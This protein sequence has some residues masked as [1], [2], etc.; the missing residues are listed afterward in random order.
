M[1]PAAGP[2]D[3]LRALRRNLLANLAGKSWGGLLNLACV[4]VYIHLMGIEAFGLVGFYLTFQAVFNV[5]DL[6]MSTTM[7]REMAK[8][9]SRSEAAQETRDL[10]RTMELVYWA[11][12]LVIGVS[13]WLL[14]PV[15]V[16]HW[17][18]VRNLDR[19][20]V[21]QCV[22]MMGVLMVLEWPL[23]LY[24][25][26]LQGTERQGLLNGVMASAAT[27]R[28]GGAILVLWLVSP[29]VTAFFVW[30]MITG[31]L[32]TAAVG[33]AFWHTLPRADR[34]A[35]FRSVLISEVAGFAGGVSAI[36][37]ESL[38]LTQSDKIVLSKILT[39]KAF[40]YYTLAW[41][42]AGGLSVVVAPVFSAFFPR[43][44]ALVH[45]GKQSE[46]VEVYHHGCELMSVVLLSAAAVFAFF[47][48]DIVAGWT[49]S[50]AIAD[51][52]YL[53]AILLVVGAALNGIAYLPYGLQ[54]AHGWTTLS[55]YMNGIV[56]L[57]MVP[58]LI[59]MAMW[60]GAIGAAIVWVLVNLSYTI[61]EV[62][63]MHRWLLHDEMSRWYISDLGLP[64]AAA[65]VIALAA[66]VIMPAP[67]AGLAGMLQIFAVLLV[68]LGFSAAIAPA[69]R[70]W[71]KAS[72]RSQLG[73]ATR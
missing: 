52:V 19:D 40:G 48:H 63:L 38:V 57:V 58:L 71:I 16:D 20:T 70:A 37:L 12:G 27:L 66:R 8:R 28:Y 49:G 29:T 30:Q 3:S 2:I 39:L 36:T 25:G 72:F 7:N 67:G 65:A 55:M 14:A 10:A 31:A 62:P 43:F 4:P 34:R 44:S 5:L 64:L 18:R 47:A 35:R 45:D 68:T 59:F 33:L 11:L 15:V 9:Q 21:L 53:V 69:T 56:V 41:T 22:E 60:Y 51:H 61:I 1:K 42:I 73:F 23:T 46:L 32:R 50:A 26:G 6:G 17:V 24:V 54:L 13:V